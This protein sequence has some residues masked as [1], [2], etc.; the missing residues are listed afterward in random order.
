MKLNSAFF[1][2]LFVFFLSCGKTTTNPPTTTKP[3][4]PPVIVTDDP[5]L[6][7]KYGKSITLGS[8][9]YTINKFS[10]LKF[11]LIDYMELVINQNG[12]NLVAHV[13]RMN[14]SAFTKNYSVEALGAGFITDRASP[15]IIMA[16]H[17]NADKKVMAIVNGDFYNLADPKGTVLGTQVS[18]GQLMKTAGGGWKMTYGITKTN[19]FFID[20]LNYTMTAGANDYAINNINSTRAENTLILYTTAFG[21]KTGTNV[22]GS[23]ILL[24]PVSGDWET[25]SNYENV[26]CE[27]VSDSPSK[28]DGGLTIPKGHIVLS[29]HGPG[30]IYVNTTKKGDKINIKIS[31]PK[32]KTGTIYDVKDAIGTPYTIL[33]N[34]IPKSTTSTSGNPGGKEPRTAV[35]HSATHFYMVAVEG[36]QVGRSDGLTTVDL[37]YL[38]KHFDATD[39]VNL[40]GGG[41]TMLAIGSYKYGQPPSATY[42]RPVPNG[43]GIVKK[44]K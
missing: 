21:E 34:G 12:L 33:E 9:N 19:E 5:E 28:V 10:T 16:T 38:L 7:A 25:Q 41:S 44:L 29:G 1:A 31:K 8:Q 22:Y 20:D 2:L 30:S 32:G 18:N 3:T 14:K 39:A 40:D 15:N 43:F 35:G 26:I 36:R 13:A 11:D 27:V 6:I 4:K 23:E 42:F 17:T 24:K 37:G